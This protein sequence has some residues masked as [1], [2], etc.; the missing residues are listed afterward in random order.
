[1]EVSR[2]RASDFDCCITAIGLRREL[3]RE[4]LVF[5]GERRNGDG[6]PVVFAG[7]PDQRDVDLAARSSAQI[8]APGILLV[9]DQGEARLPDAVRRGGVE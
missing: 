9:L 8:N 5:I 4:L 3:Q 6:L 2:T 1:M 7:A